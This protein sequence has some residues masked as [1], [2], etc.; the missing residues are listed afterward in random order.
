[1]EFVDLGM[2]T[3]KVAQLCRSVVGTE[4]QEGPGRDEE[5]FL[6]SL[7]ASRDRSLL[8]DKMYFDIYPNPYKFIIQILFYI[9]YIH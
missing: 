1:M 6:I 5:L 3:F 8:N 2:I 7:S 9:Q 4:G